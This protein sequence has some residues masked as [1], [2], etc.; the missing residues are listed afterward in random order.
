MA[1]A[2]ACV[3][4]NFPTGGKSF[5]L[6]AREIVFLRDYI[7]VATFQSL[8]G[9]QEISQANLPSELGLFS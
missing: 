7:L 9:S 8:G 4:F 1:V 2:S 3:I 6:V 5:A